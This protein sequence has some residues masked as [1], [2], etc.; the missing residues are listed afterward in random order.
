LVGTSKFTEL[1]E[2]EDL[3]VDSASIDIEVDTGEQHANWKPVG[4]DPI[5]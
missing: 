3:V 1:P 5:E 4:Q 2:G